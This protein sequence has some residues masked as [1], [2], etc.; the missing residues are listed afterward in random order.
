MIVPSRIA[1]MHILVIDDEPIARQPVTA[2]LSRA[3]VRVAHE[4]GSAVEA[5]RILRQKTVHAAICDIEMRPINGLQ[6][7]SLLRSGKC[8]PNLDGPIAL[9]PALP[10]Y[11]LTAHSQQAL[12]ERA[13][14]NR[15]NGYLTKPVTGPVLLKT[16]EKIIVDLAQAPVVGLQFSK[17]VRPEYTRFVLKGQF[18][19]SAQPVVRD[20]LKQMEGARGTNLAIDLTD[21]AFIDEYGFG[22]LLM[23]NGLVTLAGKHM[24]II[25][26]NA[27]MRG[28]LASVRLG[29]VITLYDSIIAY[30]NAMTAPGG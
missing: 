13:V 18:V 26:G 11:M 8:P 4:A 16:L 23:M 21:V 22:T 25:S 19:P 1:D 17:I 27:A 29:G 20:L 9:N 7:L 24:A 30:A 28:D 10:V 12:V 3:G 6:F 2:I 14:A 5:V 15:A